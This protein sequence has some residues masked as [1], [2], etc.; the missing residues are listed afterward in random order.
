MNE[1]KLKPA[2]KKATSSKAGAK[3]NS[4]AADK[5]RS[6][7]K[8]VAA[9]ARNSAAKKPA[10]KTAVSKTVKA[11]AVAKT[12]NPSAAGKKSPAKGPHAIKTAPQK[13]KPARINKS[14]ARPTPEDRYR[15]IETAAY[16]IA[17][18]H[19]FQGHADEHWAAAEREVAARLGG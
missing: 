8:A 11:I 1:K 3:K 12:E 18:R 19:G 17:E 16:F 9:P 2:A 10:S 13:T 7:K 6:I 14:A 15:M 4:T 5:S